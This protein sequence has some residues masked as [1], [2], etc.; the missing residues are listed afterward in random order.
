MKSMTGYGKGVIEADGRTLTIELKAVNNRYLEINSRLPKAM[1]GLDEAL[2]REIQSVIKRGSVDVYFNYE[3]ASEN[4]KT[5]T[6]DMALA[7]EY[8]AA[9]KKLRTEFC[10]DDD[11]GTT[12]LLRSPDVLKIEYGKDDPEMLARLVSECAAAAV[13]ELDK[14]REKEGASIRNDLNLLV[15]NIVNAL[16]QVVRRAPKVVEDYRKKLE[17]R[18]K[19]ALGSVEIDENKLLSEVA[20][21]ADKADINEEISRLS[22]HIAQFID[23]LNSN[24]PQ[25][26]KLDFISQEMNRE[27]NTM[28]SK[29]N[30][31]ELTEKVLYMKNELEKIKE[32]IRN[33]E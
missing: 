8:V 26:R 20:F 17:A 21:F 7:R 14:M 23:C 15:K 4:A 13:K 5:V 16:E 6:V 32:Q 30:D 9:A 27:I 25:G 22:S 11:F 19:D 1:S 12:A 28:G 3:N 31:A 10:L 24:E 29:S 18:I 2:R 33:V